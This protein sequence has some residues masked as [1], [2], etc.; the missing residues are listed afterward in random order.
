MERFFEE[1]L[2]YSTPDAYQMVVRELDANGIFLQTV[3]SGSASVGTDDTLR[4]ELKEKVQDGSMQPK[5]VYKAVYD[6]PSDSFKPVFTKE[7]TRHSSAS[8]AGLDVTT[9]KYHYNHLQGLQYEILSEDEGTQGGQAYYDGVKILHYENGSYE[10]F[11]S[12]NKGQWINDEKAVVQKT[13]NKTYV[14]QFANLGTGSWVLY[15]TITY[16]YNTANVLIEELH[17][18]LTG[19][20]LKKV[21]TYQNGNL[22]SVD[23]FIT[24]PENAA[25]WYATVSEL[26]TYNAANQLEEKRHVNIINGDPGNTFNGDRFTYTYYPAGHAAAGKLHVES[27]FMAGGPDGWQPASR[28]T[29]SYTPDGKYTSYSVESMNRGATELSHVVY[30]ET[31]DRNLLV[32]E[33]TIEYG[34][35]T[36]IAYHKKAMTYLECSTILSTHDEVAASAKILSTFPNPAQENISMA[37]NLS[38]A[39]AVTVTVLS[40]T[41]QKVR[42]LQEKHLAGGAQVLT[43]PVQDLAAG[44]YLVQVQTA[45]GTKTTRFIKN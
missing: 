3:G 16:T 36:P 14:R 43:L 31:D 33:E 28:I 30:Y 25:L 39:S 32:K 44:L 8:S 12:V 41:G 7:Y 27:K 1:R 18:D 23:Q 19:E 9:Y 6:A 4:Y 10:A 29:Y 26:R 2:T 45:D 11:R 37:F 13:G 38:K 22:I 40:Q 15:N 35:G 17:Q 5:R 21:Y 42:S 20:S 34:F 24:H